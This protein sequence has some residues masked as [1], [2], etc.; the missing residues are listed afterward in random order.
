MPERQPSRMAVLGSVFVA[1]LV[2]GV[3]TFVPNYAE[4]VKEMKRFTHTL[5]GS[6]IL[7]GGTI[8]LSLLLNFVFVELWS[9][10]EARSAKVR[11]DKK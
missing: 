6:V 8:L 3:F 9:R 7:I 5:R 10:R 1:V 2:L 11:T 4:S